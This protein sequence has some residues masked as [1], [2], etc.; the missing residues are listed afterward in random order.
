V[1]ELEDGTFLRLQPDGTYAPVTFDK[2]TAALAE[3][4]T[5]EGRPRGHVP[6]DVEIVGAA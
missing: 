3:Q 4:P 1:I 6:I 5:R 2:E